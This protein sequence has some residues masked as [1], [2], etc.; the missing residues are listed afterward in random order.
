MSLVTAAEQGGAEGDALAGERIAGAELVAGC[1]FAVGGATEGDG[2]ASAVV[3]CS[4]MG[5][6][7]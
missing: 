7:R 1:K 6:F 3:G 2:V 4:D 5:M